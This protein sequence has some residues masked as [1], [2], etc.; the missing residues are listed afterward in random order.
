MPHTESDRPDLPRSA[1]PSSDLSHV[2]SADHDG[3]APRRTWSA[4]RLVEV[5]L[6]EATLAGPAGTTDTGV[7]S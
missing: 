7:L 5:A 6:V 2:A 1:A 4:P 3:A